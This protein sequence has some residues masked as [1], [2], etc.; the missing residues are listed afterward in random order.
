MPSKWHTLSAQDAL[1]ILEV[2]RSGLSAQ[3]VLR[4][5]SLYGPNTIAQAARRSFQDIVIQ[6]IK[7]VL[8]ILLVVALLL[9]LLAGDLGDALA[10]LGVLLIN[11]SL[12]VAVE[13][14]AHR[15]LDALRR[16]DIGSARVLRAEA[17]QRVDLAE[18]VPGDVMLLEPGDAVGAD[19]RLLEA[20]E[21]Q[22][23]E[24][25]LTGESMPVSKNAAAQL[26]EA[27]VLAERSNMVYRSTLIASGSAS[28][29][30]IATGAQTE[31]GSLG[32]FA[33][34][35]QASK[36]PLDN[37]LDQL[38]KKLIWVALGVAVV[39]AALELFQGGAWR[40][41]MQFAVAL[42]VAAVPE[43]L[44]AVATVTLALGVHRMARKR[45]LVRRLSAVESLGSVTVVCTDK[46]G[47]LT[48][49]QMTAVALW[50]TAAPIPV[51]AQAGAAPDVQE[52][53]RAAV[54]ANALET[55]DPTELALLELPGRLGRK[56]A[57]D[58]QE[59]ARITFT[60]ER[61]FMATFHDTATGRHAYVKGDYS[62]V[63]DMCAAVD[64]AAVD[65]AHDALAQ[66]G[67]RVLAFAAGPARGI[68]EADLHNL[69]FLGLIGLEDPP[70]E[71]VKE[72]IKH[73]SDAGIRTVM[74][75]GDHAKTAH[76][77]A[78]ELGI[79]PAQ[80][81][82]R[83]AP[84]EKLRIV[85]RLQHQGEVVA[86]LGDG[87]NDAAALK[88][89]DVGVAMGKRGTDLARETADIVLQDDRFAT[90]ATAIDEGR[91][92]YANIRKFVF[93]LFSCNLAEILV[94]LVAALIAPAV[95]FLPLQI[96]WLNLVTDTFPALSLAFEPAEE[97]VLRQKP[98]G[99]SEQIVSCELLGTAL[100]Y[101]TLLALSTF[102]A[103]LLAGGSDSARL[104]TIAFSTLALAQTFHLGN[105]RGVGS[106]VHYTRA[107]T[108]R[109]A[110][111][112]AALIIGL[113]LLTVYWSPLAA[114][115]GQI[116]LP[117]QDWLFILPIAFV[118]TLVGQSLKLWHSHHEHR[119]HREHAY[120]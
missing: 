73:F 33:A 93:Y 45:A 77:I 18:L 8:F 60:S 9:A 14:R 90:I 48:R 118:P 13:W 50:T 47:T 75:T 72:T 74:I 87:V 103:V 92:I 25:S 71:G 49:G 2:T 109:Y 29:L 68:A 40:D 30:V 66:R 69:R 6:Q 94:I 19:A 3:Q 1:R 111:A 7:S 36:T 76:A 55:A 27:T 119:E 34:Q 38:G 102:A 53:V 80:V 95:V 91:T 43:G 26:P 81:F 32:A 22:V 99:R 21:L 57:P 28:A 100:F 97:R 52:L 67:L 61:R 54:L 112:S 41:V 64:R 44:P 39:V 104:T 106:V 15:A 51:T 59:V 11:L 37:Q 24:A 107:F 86:M 70:A 101:A 120:A 116:A 12:G 89:A 62:R 31:V 114:L 84:V 17:V 96:L 4:Q 16:M 63:V 105:A 113:Q 117:W 23:D 20:H 78:Q 65:A 56:I 82:A 83:V 85:E 35:L 115:L 42:A 88:Q 5:R 79:S 10:I 58:S 108:N 98:R 46:T 110:L